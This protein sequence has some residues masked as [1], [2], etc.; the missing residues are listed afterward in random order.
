MMDIEKH[1]YS[2]QCL[3][4]EI[5]C[6]NYF[7]YSLNSF[8]L[9]INVPLIN[10]QDLLRSGSMGSS[11]LRIRTKMKINFSHLTEYSH[12]WPREWKREGESI[13]FTDIWWAY[14]LHGCALL[15]ALPS[16]HLLGVSACTHILIS[17]FSST[18][19]EPGW[20]MSVEMVEDGLSH[21]PALL[22]VSVMAIMRALNTLPFGGLTTTWGILL[23]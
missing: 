14:S 23:I 4:R 19:E 7:Y 3:L 13:P 6:P 18:K 11:P 17:L 16:S 5:L 21:F 1:M 12:S 8:K 22:Q 15:P 20:Q 9:P 10:R 2:I